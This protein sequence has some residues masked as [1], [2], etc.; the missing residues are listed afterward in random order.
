MTV[1]SRGEVAVRRRVYAVT[2][3][4]EIFPCHKSGFPAS[5]VTRVHLASADRTGYR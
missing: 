1:R 4:E 2:R 3:S 5:R